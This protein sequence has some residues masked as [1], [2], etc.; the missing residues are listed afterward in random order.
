MQYDVATPA[1]YI[2]A[3]DDDWRRD[4]LL[5]LRQL[6][7]SID[8][9]LVERIRYKM[10]SYE[11]ERGPIFALNAQKGYVS[12]YVG[13]IDR[14]DASGELLRG[15][16]RGKGCIRFRKSTK[17]AETK[18]EAFITRALEVHRNGAG[19]GCS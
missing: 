9:E 10:L 18:I 6:L 17:I 2:E 5:S 19:I 14:V 13:D 11:D 16:D 3:L 12:L 4:T 1:E 7:R 15:L 8:R